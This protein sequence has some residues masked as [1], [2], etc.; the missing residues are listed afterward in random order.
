MWSL[1]YPQKNKEWL[2]PVKGLESQRPG[3]SAFQFRNYILP[4]AGIPWEYQ[5][6][7][8]R[9]TSKFPLLYEGYTP[10]LFRPELKSSYT[11]NDRSL[12]SH[13]VRKITLIY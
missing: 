4:T 11:R 12:T 13:F 1:A 10:L 5:H 2:A 6:C 8:L 7:Y 9:V 3:V